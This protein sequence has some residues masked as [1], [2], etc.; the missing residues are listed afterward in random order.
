MHVAYTPPIFTRVLFFCRRP[1]GWH[2][3]GLH[4]CVSLTYPFIIHLLPLLVL[5]FFPLAL[6]HLSEILINNHG[7][8]MLRCPVMGS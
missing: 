4:V 8:A 1:R 7:S 5:F 2:S 6:L 3:A